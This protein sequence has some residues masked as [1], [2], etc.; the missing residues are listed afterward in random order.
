MATQKMS[1]ELFEA[2]EEGVVLRS[3]KLPYR[4]PPGPQRQRGP[5]GPRGP[6]EPWNPRSRILD[7]K[8][9]QKLVTIFACM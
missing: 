3:K 8:K 6:R 9:I 2:K 4:D 5:R 1:S 7:Q